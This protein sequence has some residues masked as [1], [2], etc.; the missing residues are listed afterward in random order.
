MNIKMLCRR[1][2]FTST[3][4]NSLGLALS[5][6]VIIFNDSFVNFLSKPMRLTIDFNTLS[7]NGKMAL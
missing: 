2:Y 3:G 5:A 4:P 7:E 6:G 1:N